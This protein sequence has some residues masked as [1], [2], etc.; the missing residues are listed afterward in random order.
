MKSVRAGGRDGGG[1]GV[2]GVIGHYMVGLQL[3]QQTVLG[4]EEVQAHLL[5]TL[6]RFHSPQLYLCNTQN[7]RTIMSV[8]NNHILQQQQQ[9]STTPQCLINLYTNIYM[10]HVKKAT[11]KDPPKKNNKKKTKN[12]QNLFPSPKTKTRASV[13]VCYIKTI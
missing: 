13:Y 5:A 1:V 4:V 3:V 9:H 7:D 8:K 10:S 2:R 11:K 12:K 6:L